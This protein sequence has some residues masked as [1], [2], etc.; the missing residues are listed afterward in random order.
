MRRRFLVLRT[1]RGLRM[2]VV[3]RTWSRWGAGWLVVRDRRLH[4][5]LPG[6]EWFGWEVHR[7]G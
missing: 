2:A 7:R 1:G 4:R 3:G 5:G 6:A